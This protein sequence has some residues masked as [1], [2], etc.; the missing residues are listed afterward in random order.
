MK[1]SLIIPCFNEEDNIIPFYQRTEE[2]FS[3]CPEYELEYCFIDDGSKDDT[4]QKITKLAEENES[5]NSITAIRFSRNFG[6]ESAMYAGLQNSSGDL[7]CIIDVDL[8][9][10]P[11][12]AKEMSDFLMKNPDYDGVACYQEKRKES[13]FLSFCKKTFYKIINKLS[14]T[15]FQEGAS[16][17]RTLRRSVVDALLLL[18]E[19]NRF[20]KGLFSWLGFNIHYMPYRVMERRHGNT[21]WSFFKLL[22]YAITGFVGFSTAPLRIATWLG[23]ISSFVAGICL[24]AL[25]IQKIFFGISVSGYATIVGFILLIGGIQMILLGIIGEYLARAYIESKNRPIYIIKSKISSDK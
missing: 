18:E 10:D 19:N 8:Q 3:V 11:S 9:Q 20:S 21:S 4:W 13:A 15:P 5:K 23:L 7:M 14:E 24:V 1:L 12:Y 16:D 17:F 6:K 22:R 2:V 25:F